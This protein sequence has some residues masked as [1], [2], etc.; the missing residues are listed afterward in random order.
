MLDLDALTGS[1]ETVKLEDIEYKVPRGMNSLT[2]RAVA[3]GKKAMRGIAKLAKGSDEDVE[4]ED[5]E[6]INH[7]LFLATGIPVETLEKRSLNDL[8]ALIQLMMPA[9]KPD[10]KE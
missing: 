4:E 2:L 3:A 6:K 10:E 5:I 9:P 7:F 1:H 8:T